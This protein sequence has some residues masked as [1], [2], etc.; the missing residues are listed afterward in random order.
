MLTTVPSSN[1]NNGKHGFHGIDDHIWQCTLSLSLHLGSQLPANAPRLTN[2][3]SADGV[4]DFDKVIKESGFDNV[5]KDEFAYELGQRL[6]DRFGLDRD[7]PI[8]YG[9]A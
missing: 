2:T 8:F 1:E 6:V 9:I 3:T 4:D 5:V 7:E